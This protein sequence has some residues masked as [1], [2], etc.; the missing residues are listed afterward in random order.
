MQQAAVIDEEG[1]HSPHC[2]K[3]LVETYRVVRI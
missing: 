1:H 3:E 2:F